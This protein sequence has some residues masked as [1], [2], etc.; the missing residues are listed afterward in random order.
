MYASP[1]K[2]SHLAPFPLEHVYLLQ[3]EFFSQPV[4]GGGVFTAAVDVVVET[5]GGLVVVI[6]GG[7]AEVVA[8][9]LA[10]VS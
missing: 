1:E 10:Q 3:S 5:G 9:Q 8:T 2:R 4:L 6:G 7:G